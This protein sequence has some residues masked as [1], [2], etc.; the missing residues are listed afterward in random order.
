MRLNYFYNGKF[1]EKKILIVDDSKEDDAL[2]KHFLELE[3]REYTT[4][5]AKDGLEALENNF[6]KTVYS[7]NIFLLLG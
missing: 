6:S 7:K 2:V 3:G 5:L 4:V 1:N